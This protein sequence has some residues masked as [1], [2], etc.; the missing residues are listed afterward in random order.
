MEDP[1]KR[2]VISTE[3]APKRKEITPQEI[4]VVIRQDE[5]RLKT[6]PGERAK[7]IKQLIAERKQIVA[8]MRKG[9]LKIYQR[10]PVRER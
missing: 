4:E 1:P 10:I 6:F 3:G 5:E 8:R 2:R 7:Q 9:E